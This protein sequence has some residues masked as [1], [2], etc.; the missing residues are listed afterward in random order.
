MD[1]QE[2]TPGATALF[3]KCA[4]IDPNRSLVFW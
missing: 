3:K 1:N 4:I 2:D